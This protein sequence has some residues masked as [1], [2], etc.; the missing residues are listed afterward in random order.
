MSSSDLVVVD[1]T[2]QCPMTELTLVDS[3]FRTV[4]SGVGRL[5]AALPAGLYE[6]IA[7]AG[8]GNHKEIIALRGTKNYVRHGIEVPFDTVAPAPH[9]SEADFVRTMSE[10]LIKGRAEGTAG[11]IVVVD[12]AGRESVELLD[13]NSRPASGTPGWI[14]AE[15]AAVAA[16]PQ[17][18]AP[19][20]YLL[21]FPGGVSARSL[22]LWLLPDFETVVF[23]P[24]GENGLDL[25]AAV[26]HVS[27]AS[28]PW[29][30]DRDRDVLLEAL[31]RR[32]QSPCPAV[33]D[34][35]LEP[36]CRWADA[37]MLALCAAVL[38]HGAGHHQS[39]PL[40]MLV[41]N[42]LEGHADVAALEAST[43]AAGAVSWPPLL[44]ATY[45]RTLLPADHAGA[46]V[47]QPGSRLSEFALGLS[48]AG[49]YVTVAADPTDAGQWARKHLR[50]LARVDHH[51]LRTAIEHHD[52]QTV[53]V[54]T[55]LPLEAAQ[56]VTAAAQPGFEDARQAWLEVLKASLA[57]DPQA[58]WV[59]VPGHREWR[60]A[61][62]TVSFRCDWDPTR[63]LVRAAA[64]SENLPRQFPL[65]LSHGDD[66]VRHLAQ[67][68]DGIATWAADAQARYRV[69]VPDVERI[70]DHVAFEALSLAPDPVATFSTVDEPLRR[71][72]IIAEGRLRLATFERSDH[73]LEL[74]VRS[75]DREDEGSYAVVGVRGPGMRDEELVVPLIW[76]NT[77]REAS[78]SLRVGRPR[79]G[80]SV[81]VVPDLQA[82]GELSVEIVRRSID[83]AANRVTERALVD[84]FERLGGASS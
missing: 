77:Q 6:L 53:A 42:V 37:P 54:Q 81:F 39:E 22:P 65:L 35:L 17:E 46:P 4:A 13:E 76:L 75:Q 40:T 59:T 38:A 84:L 32:L 28:A 26:V 8:D 3:D 66:N 69:I 11:L 63:S 36:V 68:V 9:T 41:A 2:A 18:L 74:T 1:L 52:V 56:R 7:T 21:R 57:A 72:T 71:V 73:D 34:D 23:V 27:P 47:I 80:A 25:G 83:F 29:Q 70:G 16:W 15:G 12:G 79:A 33:P 58:M 50:A 51:P 64:L 10:A 31:L 14:D 19:G 62:E 82:A 60:I 5:D 55:R 24:A 67:F 44:A 45:W 78:G 48:W 43:G 20:G 61:G 49:P 30:P